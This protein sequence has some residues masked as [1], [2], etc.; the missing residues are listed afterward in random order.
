M[1]RRTVALAAVLVSAGAGAAQAFCGFYV[2]AATGDLYNDSSQVAIARDGERTTISMFNDYKGDPKEF[3]LVV[4]VP[5][6]IKKEDVKTVRPELFAHL[7]QWSAPRLVEYWEEDPCYVPPPMKY[8]ATADTARRGGA[9]DK[10]E[11]LG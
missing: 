8:K 11:A 3:A 1:R 2:A 5:P 10:D 9:A 4:P 6:G 7:D